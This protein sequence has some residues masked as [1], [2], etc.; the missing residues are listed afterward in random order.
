LSWGYNFKFDFLV[1]Y[2]EF[3][4]SGK[5]IA[6]LVDNR[7]IYTF[8]FEKLASSAAGGVVPQKKSIDLAAHQARYDIEGTTCVLK[9][10]WM[11]EE[12]IFLCSS[13]QCYTLNLENSEV[14]WAG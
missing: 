4:P 5:K 7:T 1:N 10:V 2:Y 6:F 12:T 8:D 13:T 11:D 9:F 14:T 3:S